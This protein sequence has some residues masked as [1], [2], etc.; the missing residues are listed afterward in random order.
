[1]FWVYH[2][3]NSYIFFIRITMVINETIKKIRI[4]HR[5]YLTFNRF[6]FKL[7]SIINSITEFNTPNFYFNFYKEN[8]FFEVVG[9][10]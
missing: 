8:A 2:G 6:F 1:M 3:K 7:Y 9:P 10:A 5:K 4:R